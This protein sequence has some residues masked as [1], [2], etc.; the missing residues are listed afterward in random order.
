MKTAAKI[1]GSYVD[2]R[3]VRTYVERCGVGQPVVC[4]HTAGRDSRQW[5]W[6]MQELASDF[7]LIAFDYP[8]QGMSWPLA[9]IR[10]IEYPD[11]LCY[12]LWR[13]VNGAGVRRRGQRSR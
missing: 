4:L 11:L 12:F 13:V 9:G 1:A 2:V 8:G 10:C 7:E 5:H 3:G 6:L